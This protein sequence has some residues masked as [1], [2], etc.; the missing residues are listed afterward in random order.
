MGLDDL[1]YDVLDALLS[2]CESGFMPSGQE[3]QT[4][5]GLREF[6]EDKQINDKNKQLYCR[7]LKRLIQHGIFDDTEILVQYEFTPANKLQMAQQIIDSAKNNISYILAKG[8][9]SGEYEYVMYNIEWL[10]N[11]CH[12]INKVA[13]ATGNNDFI[14]EIKTYTNKLPVFEYSATYRINNMLL[15]INKFHTR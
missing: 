7:I 5:I 15:T 10:R 9:E 13:R 12:S 2:L 3:C 4:L 6:F 11:I 8:F 1:N 14:K